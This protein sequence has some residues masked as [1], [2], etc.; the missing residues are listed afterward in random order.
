MTYIEVE[1]DNNVRGSAPTKL[2]IAPK[3]P[4]GGLA[5]R[6]KAFRTSDGIAEESFG[7]FLGDKT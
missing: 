2:G 3:N 6:P 5:G 7:K 1:E 4:N